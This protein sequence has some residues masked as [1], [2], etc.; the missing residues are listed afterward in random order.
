MNKEKNQRIFLGIS[1]GKITR[2]IQGQENPETF[3]DVEGHLK[4]ITVRS[5]EIKGQQTPFLD[6]I[7]EDGEDTYDLSVQKNSGVARSILL[8]LASV[9]D[10]VGNI[11]RI[12]P[13]LSKD[14]EHTNIAVYVNKQKVSWVC[15]ASKIPPL[16][17][18]QV[19]TQQVADD[20]A[21][22]K[23]FD[24]HLAVIQN[25]LNAASATPQAAVAP[26]NV[27]DIPDGGDFF[28]GGDQHL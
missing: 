13:Y 22:S 12:S 6:F 3:T 25:R 14:G 11:V 26:S 20:S 23:F 19:G 28:A 27:E 17:Y 1:Y 15:E 5:A 16:K 2:K 24:Q 4:E 7:I 9:Q 8:S 21:R 10:F 18:V